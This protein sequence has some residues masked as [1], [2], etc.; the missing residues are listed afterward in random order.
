M[1][2]TAYLPL[3]PWQFTMENFS[4]PHPYVSPRSIWDKKKLREAEK[5]F[6]GCLSKILDNNY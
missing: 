6:A 5:I 2:K 3:P 1:I 4:M